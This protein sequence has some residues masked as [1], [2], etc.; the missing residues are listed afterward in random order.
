MLRYTLTRQIY[1]CMPWY[2]G[3]RILEASADAS[4]SYGSDIARREAGWPSPL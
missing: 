4:T 1:R 2:P 3:A